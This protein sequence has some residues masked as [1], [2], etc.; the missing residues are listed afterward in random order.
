[1]RRADRRRELGA[2][3]LGLGGV[4]ALGGSIQPW[5]IVHYSPRF[6]GIQIATLGKITHR[7]RGLDFADG[8]V[9]LAVAAAL[10]LAGIVALFVS[11]I[12]S[13]VV[14]AGAAAAAGVFLLGF[15]AYDTTQVH[16]VALDRFNPFRSDQPL[17]TLHLRE[18]LSVSRSYGLYLVMAGGAVAMAGA[19]L[20]S[21][22]RI[23]EPVG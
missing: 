8:K 11:R 22:A 2:F 4:L 21:T 13:G 5:A 15:G 18:L 7:I 9:T 23:R 14:I 3:A 17:T 6:L 19:W 10:V 12:E 1:V 20:L 16:D